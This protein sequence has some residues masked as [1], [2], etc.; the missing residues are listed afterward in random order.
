MD[1]IDFSH[2][3]GYE[4]LPNRGIARKPAK[5]QIRKFIWKDFC[6][7]N[8]HLGRIFDNPKIALCGFHIQKFYNW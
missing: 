2:V 4:R 5:R 6:L 3:I 8:N 1:H 7:R